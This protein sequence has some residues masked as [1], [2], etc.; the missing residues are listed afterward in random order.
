MKAIIVYRNG[1]TFDCGVVENAKVL[2]GLSAKKRCFSYLKLDSKTSPEFASRLA[3]ADC[4]KQKGAVHVPAVVKSVKGWPDDSK[5]L[6]Y[7]VKME[8]KQPENGIDTIVLLFEDDEG[9]QLQEAFGSVVGVYGWN[10]EAHRMS[11][12]DKDRYVV[13]LVISRNMEF[14]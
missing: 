2:Q 3:A 14:F 10:V 7:A 8:S 11:A 1:S 13:S 9:Q 12:R 6:E 4:V 5:L